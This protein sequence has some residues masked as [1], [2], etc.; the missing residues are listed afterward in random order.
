MSAGRPRA[1]LLPT[2]D[3]RFFAPPEPIRCHRLPVDA[4]PRVIQY[5]GKQQQGRFCI[6]FTY[7]LPIIFGVFLPIFLLHA[8]RRRQRRLVSRRRQQRRTGQQKEASV[9][10]ELIQS[11]IGKTCQISTGTLGESFDK[12]T[13]EE[14]KENWIRVRRKGKAQLINTD[15]I[16]SV[17]VLKES[18]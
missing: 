18:G 4:D 10:N 12:A 15:Y 14:A 1:D 11:L 17:K 2:G 6:E 9:T 8:R 16:T 7:I 3:L 13:V 5:R